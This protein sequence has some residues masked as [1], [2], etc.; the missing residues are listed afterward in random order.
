MRTISS[1]EKKIPGMYAS[2]TNVT[3]GKSGYL[4]AAGVQ[5]VASEK[6]HH[7]DVITPY[8]GYSVLLANKTVGLIWYHNMLGGSKMQN[9][10][11]STEAVT[12]DG[13]RICPLT[14]WDSKITTVLAMLGGITDIIRDQL[15][16]ENKYQK[17]NQIVE[18]EWSRVF[19]DIRGEKLDFE[20]PSKK[21][22]NVMKNF[23]N[24]Q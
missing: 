18:K 9:R 11:G 22:P 5:E 10:F 6:V 16:I 12:L 17:F 8:G 7:K 21:L 20:F 23:K 14:T 13:K 1:F 19:Q 4:S 3:H 2:V 24:C 15:K